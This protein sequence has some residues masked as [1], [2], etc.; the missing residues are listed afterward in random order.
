MCT[1]STYL[2]HLMYATIAP[3]IKEYSMD[4][5]KY[6]PTRVKNNRKWPLANFRNPSHVLITSLRFESFHS[7]GK[8]GLYTDKKTWLKNRL[9][10]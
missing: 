8:Q 3:F 7:T 10:N 1:T 6:R 9:K 2:L 4:R 5:L